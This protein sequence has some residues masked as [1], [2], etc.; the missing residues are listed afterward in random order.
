MENDLLIDS[1]PA[2]DILN[3]TLQYQTKEDFLLMLHNIATAQGFTDLAKKTGLSREGLYKI[4]HPL[5]NP[6]LT[7]LKKI[8][9][10][11]GFELQVKKITN[12]FREIRNFDVKILHSIDS[13]YPDLAEHWHPNKNGILT[14]KDLA[15]TSR[16]KIWW[17]CPKNDQH[18][19]EDIVNN[20]VKSFKL[21]FLKNRKYTKE[22]FIGQLKEICPFCIE[23]KEEL[24]F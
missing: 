5:G 21:K 19:W 15:I 9:V 1:Y 4:L 6:K 22:S 8:L 2:V 13:I 18:V 12:D 14:P 24:T 16:K 3:I 23:H 7:V 20:L 17:K 10:A 11:M